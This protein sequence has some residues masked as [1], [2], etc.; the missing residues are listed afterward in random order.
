MSAVMASAQP[1]VGDR[2]VRDLEVVRASLTYVR[3]MVHIT[4]GD[5]EPLDAL[6][7]TAALDA[8]MSL[9]DRDASLHGAYGGATAS[10]P[11]DLRRP[12]SMNAMAQSLGLPFETVRRR[13][14]RMARAELCV[15][16]PRGVVIPHRAVTSTA[17]AAEQRARFDRTRVLFRTLVDLDAAPVGTM[18]AWPASGPPVRAVNWAVSA[19]ALRAC[20]GLI[21]LTGNVATSLVLLEL[22][23]ANMLT[24][25]PAALAGW[26]RDPVRFGVPVR[27]AALAA[28]VRLPGET[29]RRHL[30][31][32]AALGFSVRRPNGF[33]AAA[34]DTV[35]PTL[36]R[37]VRANSEHLRRLLH[38]LDQ[39]GVLTAWDERLDT[40]CVVRRLRG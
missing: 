2:D 23:L 40:P 8:N 19:Y 20:G 26:V 21:D 7:F 5:R 32:L 30:H 27:I 24:L 39:L 22:A 25:S 37:L 28:L 29:V 6:I 3:D 10:A 13:L 12:V 1:I 33:V 4:R 35:A 34:P 9:V 36:A 14:L 31:A 11:D 16:G 17:Y 18:R 15:I 38:R